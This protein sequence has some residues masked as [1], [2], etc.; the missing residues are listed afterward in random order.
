MTDSVLSSFGTH[1]TGSDVRDASPGVSS[2]QEHFGGSTSGANSSRFG[3]GQTVPST[4]SPGHSELMLVLDVTDAGHGSVTAK[5]CGTVASSA[6][7][8]VFGSRTFALHSQAV[9][10]QTDSLSDIGATSPTLSG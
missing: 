7:L 5:L 10:Y 9:A 2:E 6:S 4:G 1:F 8:S 3:A